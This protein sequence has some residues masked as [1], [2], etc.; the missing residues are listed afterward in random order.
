MEGLRL[1]AA[2]HCVS[3]LRATQPQGDISVL[4]PQN[5]AFAGDA[6]YCN[7]VQGDEKRVDE[8]RDCIGVLFNEQMVQRLITYVS[9]PVRHVVAQIARRA[10][11]RRIAPGLP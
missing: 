4:C 1:A 2:G 5:S 10:D 11:I 9:P 3:K 8:Q 6:A 7:C